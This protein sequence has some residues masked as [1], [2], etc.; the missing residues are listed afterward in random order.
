[1]NEEFRSFMP[2]VFILGIV[3]FIA[4][5]LTLSRGWVDDSKTQ[6]SGAVKIAVV[7][8]LFQ[9]VHFSEELATGLY[10]RLPA[11]FGLPPVSVRTFVS[12]NLAALVIWC[13]C[14]LGLAV[15]IRVA[16]FPLWFLG[17][18]SVMN[19]VLH[20]LLAILTGGYFPGLVTSPLV[21]VMGI[22]F[23]LRLLMVTECAET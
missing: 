9:A 18:A 8:I 2:S 22:L 21:G 1:M 7:A 15:K 14:A 3:A 19:G 17:I 4:L 16:L 11:L 23:L 20:P 5:Y 13:F 12:F 10:E 6:I